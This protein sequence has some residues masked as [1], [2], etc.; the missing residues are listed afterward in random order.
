MERWTKQN[1]KKENGKGIDMASC[2]IWMWN[3]DAAKKGKKQIGGIGNVVVEKF[4][5]DQ[6]AGE[7][8]Q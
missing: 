6:V 7:D 5:K 8:K 4:E 1:I 3:M 2:V